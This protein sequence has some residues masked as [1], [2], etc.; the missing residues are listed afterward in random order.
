LRKWSEMFSEGFV[1]HLRYHSARYHMDLLFDG[2]VWPH[3]RIKGFMLATIWPELFM[4]CQRKIYVIANNLVILQKVIPHLQSLPVHGSRATD[5]FL[6]WVRCEGT[7]LYLLCL[8]SIT[9]RKPILTGMSNHIK[10]RLVQQKV[11]IH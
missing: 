8:V 11:G 7:H 1:Y 4:N 5:C 6:T 2:T 9:Y 10:C 3:I